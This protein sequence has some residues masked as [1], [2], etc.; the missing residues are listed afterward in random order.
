M[1]TAKKNTWKW[2]GA[3]TNEN[4]AT[5]AEFWVFENKL[6]FDKENHGRSVDYSLPLFAEDRTTKCVQVC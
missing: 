2:F 6:N 4:T 5:S 3:E 1:N